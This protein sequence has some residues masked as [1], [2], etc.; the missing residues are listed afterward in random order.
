MGAQGADLSLVLA[1]VSA[2]NAGGRG[3]RGRLIAFEGGEASGKST[4]SARLASRLGA[5]LTREPGDTELGRH[6]RQLVLG[7]GIAEGIDAR[8]EAL[9]LAADRAQHV[10]SVIRPALLAGRDV[11]TDRYAGSSL[12]Y[13]GFGRGLGV[14]DIRWLS[15]W[16]SGGLWP[17]LVILLDVPDAVATERLVRSGVGLDRLEAAGDEFHRRVAQGFRTLAESSPETWRV[18]DGTGAVDEVAVKVAEEV[19]AFFAA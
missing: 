11:V 2:R 3:V 12:A 9:L 14:A 10:A 4:Q 19:R 13:Q 5:V 6:I 1:A 15:D 7:P 16:A 17:D 18:V 8:A